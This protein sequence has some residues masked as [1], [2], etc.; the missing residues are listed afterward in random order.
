[1]K[2][3]KNMNKKTAYEKTKDSANNQYYRYLNDIMKNI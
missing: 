2:K 1:M 3:Q